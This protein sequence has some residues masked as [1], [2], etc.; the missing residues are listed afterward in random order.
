[1]YGV[2]VSREQYNNYTNKKYVF[3]TAAGQTW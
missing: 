2:N 3:S 1:M